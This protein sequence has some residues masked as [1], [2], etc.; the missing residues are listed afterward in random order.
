MDVSHYHHGHHWKGGC[1]KGNKE[2]AWK[3][4]KISLHIK[5]FLGFFQVRTEKL[6]KKKR[7]WPRF[8][9]AASFHQ[10]RSRRHTPFPLQTHKLS[11]PL[12]T[13][14]SIEKKLHGHK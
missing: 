5:F 8:L 3:T 11:I 9:K 12:P 6:K 10:M 14:A 2:N 1:L 4:S 7:F 13:N